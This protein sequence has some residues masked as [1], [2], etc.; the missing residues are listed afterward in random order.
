MWRRPQLRLLLAMERRINFTLQDMRP[1]C[2]AHNH[3]L[4]HFVQV[5][6]LSGGAQCTLQ[7]VW[8]ASEPPQSLTTQEAD[9]DKEGTPWQSLVLLGQQIPL[10]SIPRQFP[11]DRTDDLEMWVLWPDHSLLSQPVQYT[12]ETTA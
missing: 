1:S 4:S 6:L 8:E 11:Y 5:D 7:R 2:R 3:F 9:K 12:M 10:S